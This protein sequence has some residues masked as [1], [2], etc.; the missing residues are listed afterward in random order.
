M[1]SNDTIGGYTLGELLG[2]DPI[3]KPEPKK[4]GAV[5]KIVGAPFKLI[6]A[7]LKLPVTVVSRLVGG[8]GGAI[9]EIAKLPV[10]LVGALA[11]PWRKN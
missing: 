8:I 2:A 11:K 1:A 5:A 3:K 7:I 4:K 9:G 10:R 6:G